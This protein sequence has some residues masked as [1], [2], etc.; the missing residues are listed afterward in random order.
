[1]KK[2][3]R[4]RNSVSHAREGFMH[5]VRHEPNMRIHLMFAIA[6]IPLAWLLDIPWRDSLLVVFAVFLVLI[7][8]MIN[9]AIESTVNLVSEQHHKW[10]KIAKD[11]A[12]SAVL[13]A[14]V[15]SIIIGLAVFLPPIL[16]LIGR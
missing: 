11:T 14:A 3:E 4:F 2:W 7:S 5:A 15:L 9:T 8:E 1:M 10:A 6:V 12:A 13:L 16:R